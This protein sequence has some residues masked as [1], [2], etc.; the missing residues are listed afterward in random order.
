MMDMT[1]SDFKAELRRQSNFLKYREKCETLPDD[2]LVEIVNAA[3]RVEWQHDL[4]TANIDPYALTLDEYYRYLE[5]LEV[6]HNIDKALRNDKKRKAENEEGD[7]E[8]PTHKKR[9]RK[10]GL[11]I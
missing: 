6:K 7:N 3:K 9:A 5:K 2:K 4:L 8:K 11:G 10:D 1:L